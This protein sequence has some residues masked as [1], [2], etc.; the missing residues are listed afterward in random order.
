M[1]FLKERSLP[2]ALCAA[3]MLLRQKENGTAYG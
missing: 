2:S 1:I 3:A